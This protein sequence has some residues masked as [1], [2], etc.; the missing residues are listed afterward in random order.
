MDENMAGR[1]DYGDSRRAGMRDA[2]VHFSLPGEGLRKGKIVVSGRIYN[3]VW[4]E[5][6]KAKS[7]EI[8]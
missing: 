4:V 6:K 1:E 7:F 5:G 2:D 8:L 3:K